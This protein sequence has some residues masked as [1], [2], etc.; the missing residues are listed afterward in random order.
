[1]DRIAACTI[2]ANSHLASARVVASSFQRHHP[3]VPFFVLVADELDGRLEPDEE[4]FTTLRLDELDDPRITRLRF[5]YGQQALS[6]ALTPYAI[7][8]LLD[9]GYEGVIFVKQESLVLGELSLFTSLLDRRSVLLTPHLRSP[10]RGEE[11]TS[12][13]LNILLSGSYNGGVVGVSGRPEGRAFLEWWQD[14]LSTHCRHAVGQGIHWEQRW[15]DLVPAL[16]DEVEI[17]RDPG[18]NVG[19]WSFPERIVRVSDGDV[20]VDELPCRLLRFSG[21]SPEDPERVTRYSDRLAVADLGEAAGLFE[22][23]REELFAAGYEQT[24]DRPYAFDRFDNGVAIPELV[25]SM[26]LELGE[27][28]AAFGDPFRVGPGSFFAWLNEPAGR[29]SWGRR[30]S[31]LWLEVHRRRPDVRGA[32]PDVL[33]VDRRAFL[34]W[35]GVHGAEEY[36]VPPELARA[37]RRG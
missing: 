15:L 32:F 2:A 7:E 18:Y 33:G 30:V 35:V 11:G 21:Y 36:G 10:L 3:G 24:R 28:A 23:Y 27:R 22:H 25:R 19:H 9:R 12:R 14:R 26:Y 5:G 8:H 6:Y 4:S 17:V 29:R 31:R 20:S 16:F 37:G 13:E 34:D 1:M